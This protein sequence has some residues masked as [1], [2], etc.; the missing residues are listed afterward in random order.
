M[1]YSLF[2]IFL[3]TINVN[4]NGEIKVVIIHEY[5][6][7]HCAL[8]FRSFMQSLCHTQMNLAVNQYMR[9]MMFC[10]CGAQ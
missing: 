6:L 3:L 7:L 2:L 9:G 5:Y 4:L 10:I 8:I 1:Q